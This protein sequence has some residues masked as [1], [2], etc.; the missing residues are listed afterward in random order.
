MTLFLD[1]SVI[2][3]DG[4]TKEE[5]AAVLKKFDIKSPLT[6]NPLTEPI[7]EE[8][9]LKLRLRSDPTFPFRVQPD[10]PDPHRS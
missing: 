3:L 10:V 5:M 1:V 8:N 7:G 6:N 2:K 9:I 4:M